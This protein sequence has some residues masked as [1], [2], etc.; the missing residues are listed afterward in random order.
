MKESLISLYVQ[1]GDKQA[2]DKLLAIAKNEE[3]AGLRR[4]TISQLSRSEDP[5]VKEF[6][7]DL[8]ER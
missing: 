2:I 7:K 5:R 8:I 6:L 3:N 1:S 4:R